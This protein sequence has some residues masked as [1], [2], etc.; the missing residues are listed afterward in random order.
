MKEFHKS[1]VTVLTLFII[2]AII[3]LATLLNEQH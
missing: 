1:V 3:Y 2:Y